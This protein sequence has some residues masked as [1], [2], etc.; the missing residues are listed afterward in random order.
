[1]FTIYVM[2]TH[3]HIYIYITNKV[4]VK[5]TY[6]FDWKMAIE[7]RSEA[8][9]YVFSCKCENLVDWMEHDR[10]HNVSIIRLYP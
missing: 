9:M 8:L 3:T 10:Y 5:E 6:S 7:I 1:M 2:H 4:L